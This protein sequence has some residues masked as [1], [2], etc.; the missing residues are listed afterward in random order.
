MIKCCNVL[1]SCQVL[2]FVA[3]KNEERAGLGQELLR[4]A[5]LYHSAGRTPTSTNE[6]T[7]KHQTFLACTMRLSLAYHVSFFFRVVILSYQCPVHTDTNDLAAHVL[8][9]RESWKCSLNLY[10]LLVLFVPYHTQ[11]V[12][13]VL[14]SGTVWD[15]KR[16][17]LL[18]GVEQLAL[19]GLQFE[20]HDQLSNN[21]WQ[22]V[23]G[24]A[25]TAKWDCT[26]WRCVCFWLFLS[27]LNF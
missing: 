8:C 24:N 12:P 16:A 11:V 2:G 7:W 6:A 1:T 25:F 3:H 27:F 9:N 5:D 21:Q 19:Q 23:A 17:R 14:P 20:N 13:T 4:F 18:I 15:M 22:D 26:L 10:V